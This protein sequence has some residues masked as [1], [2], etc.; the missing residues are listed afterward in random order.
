[1]AASSQNVPFPNDTPSLNFP[2]F[3][4]GVPPTPAKV[5]VFAADGRVSWAA[6]S[7]TDYNSR[8]NCYAVLLDGAAAVPQYGLGSEPAAGPATPAELNW[9]PRVRL[10]FSAE[11]PFVFAKRY[12]DANASRA[13]AESLLRYSLYI[14]S[15]PIDDLPPVSTEQ[16]WVDSGIGTGHQSSVQL[17]TGRYSAGFAP[18][19]SDLLPHPPPAPLRAT[20]PA[21]LHLWTPPTPPP[22]P[23]PFRPTACWASRS[24]A[25]S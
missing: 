4:P 6:C 13:R 16:V 20:P 14:D 22:P 23:A 3:T 25:R 2:R 15:M 19:L 9:V 21:S 8:T 12:T 24:T 18:R 17:T 1:M 11:D 10:Y 7:V 5:A